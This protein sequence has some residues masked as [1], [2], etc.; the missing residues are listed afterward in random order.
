MSLGV[1][2]SKS[3]RN[4][5]F[6]RAHG[7]IALLLIGG[8]SARAQSDNTQPSAEDVLKRLAAAE[9]EIKRLEVIVANQNAN[10][11]VPATPAAT[12]PPTV[13]PAESSPP[14]SGQPSPMS[15]APGAQPE[16]A[17]TSAA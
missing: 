11:K 4:A 16:T 6:I 13:A 15:S 1:I 10:G 5:H 14:P 17:P 7:L 3:F 9:A 2:V 8:V 12:A